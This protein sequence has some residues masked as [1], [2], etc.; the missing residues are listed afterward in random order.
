MR[1][2]SGAKGKSN[3]K[4]L[5]ALTSV[6]AALT[7]SGCFFTEAAS[8]TSFSGSSPCSSTNKDKTDMSGI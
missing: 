4:L 5:A 8:A 2:S 1:H 7:G 6:A 3:K